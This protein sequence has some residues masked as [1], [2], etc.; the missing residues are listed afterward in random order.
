MAH[1]QSTAAK[2][3]PR[4]FLTKAEGRQVAANAATSPLLARSLAQAKATIALALAA[5]IETPPPGEAGG[6]A[7]EKHKQNYREMQLAGMLYTI[8]GEA[9]YAAWV[10]KVL[11]QYASMYPAL[12][13]HPMSRNQAPGKLFHQ[14]L[15]EATWLVAVSIAYDCVYDA[16][17]PAQRARI[18]RDE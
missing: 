8:T 5:P 2:G 7:H 17:A 6:Y 12:G 9:R 15:N 13:P 10:G 3:H 16:L 14:S 18:E 4:I 1:G 11:E